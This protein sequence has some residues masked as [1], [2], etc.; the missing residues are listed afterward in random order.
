MITMSP[1]FKVGTR[2]LRTYSMKITAFIGRSMT[3][4]AVISSCRSAATKVTV[5]QCPHGIRPM[6]RRPRLA[7]PRR[8]AILV[9]VPVSSMKTKRA[10]S[11]DACSASQSARAWATSGRSCSAACTVFF[12]PVVLTLEEA[13]DRAIAHLHAPMLQL[14]PKLF[15]R[16]IRLRSDPRQKPFPFIVQPRSVIATHGLGRYAARLLPAIDPTDHRT[17]P[18]RKQ[19][20][21][22]LPRQTT[23]N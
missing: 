2:H 13:P 4:G 22:L 23:F 5:F 20:S 7:R 19:R 15:Q 9:Q 12:K 8:R 1:G 18:N 16:Q 6:T 10:G 11:R 17:H 21:R 3:K 14:T